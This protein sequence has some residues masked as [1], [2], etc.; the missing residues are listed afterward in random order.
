MPSRARLE[1]RLLA[2]AFRCLDILIGVG[3]AVLVTALGA[4]MVAGV[5]AI[6]ALIGLRL[7]GAYAFPRKQALGAHMARVGL[8]LGVGFLIAT[9]ASLASASSEAPVVWTL[10]AATGV[11]AGAHG[12][13]WTLIARGRAQGHLTP[14]I[15]VVGATKNAE[16]LIEAAMRTGE[17]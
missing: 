14:N 2:R 15:V 4:P 16:R 9:G 1:T 8:P 10:L 7:A 5:W 11:L 13:W 6:A 3:V 17:V 12:V